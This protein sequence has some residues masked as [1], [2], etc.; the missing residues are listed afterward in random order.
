MVKSEL[1]AEQ[2]QRIAR[3]KMPEREWRSAVKEAAARFGWE[4]LIE[5]PDQ[6]YMEL[7]NVLM[8][9]NPVTKRREAIS[10]Q[11]ISTL[12]AIKAWPDLFYGSRKLGRAIALELKVGKN[13]ADP[14]QKEKLQLLNDCGIPARV[15]RPEQLE[16]LDLVLEGVG[17][18]R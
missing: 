6:A 16:E 17:D 5:I 9:F 4:S 14:A 8:P 2:Y 1:S 18:G 11:A 13:T 15:W 10:K 3:G 12:K 7:V